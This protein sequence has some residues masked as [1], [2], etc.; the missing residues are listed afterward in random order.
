MFT[1]DHL[2]QLIQS[3]GLWLLAPFAIIEGPIVTVIAAYIA[4]MG[5]MNVYAV[6]VVCA[7]ADLVGDAMYYGIGRL[8]PAF[9]PERWLARMGMG[10]ARQLAL[11]DHFATKGGRTLLFGKWTHSTGL[12]IMLASGMARMNFLSYM[13]YNLIGTVPKTAVFVALGYFIGQAYSSID[14]YIARISLGLLLAALVVV[15]YIWY[16]KK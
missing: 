15:L 5:Y 9:L 16:R 12:P 7:V 13:W 2:L 11:S 3:Y 14:T 6:Y 10:Q 1:L 8:G 4:R